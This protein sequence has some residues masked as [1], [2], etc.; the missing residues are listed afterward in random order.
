[1]I[2]SPIPPPPKKNRIRQCPQL[3]PPGFSPVLGLMSPILI[4]QGSDAYTRANYLLPVCL[5]SDPQTFSKTNRNI[6]VIEEIYNH[7]DVSCLS[8][9]VNV[10][11]IPL[12]KDFL[13]ILYSPKIKKNSRQ[14]KCQFCLFWILTCTIVY[15]L[16]VQEVV[17]HFTQ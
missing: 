4:I 1:M 5:Q 14:K 10:I 2:R 3:R 12:G 15:I 17:T 7:Q 13:D 11:A 16:F 9:V 8:K 6:F